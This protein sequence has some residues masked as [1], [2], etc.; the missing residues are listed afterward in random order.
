MTLDGVLMKITSHHRNYNSNTR[1][2]DG[3]DQKLS[4]ELSDAAEAESIVEPLEEV[5]DVDA[6]EFE[7][8]S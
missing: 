8:T 6:P 3:K 7:H 1:S 4:T 5:R 2:H